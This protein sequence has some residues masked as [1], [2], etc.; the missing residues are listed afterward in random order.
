MDKGAEKLKNK[1]GK[2]IALHGSYFHHNF[3]DILLMDILTKWIR[4]YDKNYKVFLPFAPDDT[5]KSIGADGN[6]ISSIF[7]ADALVYGG[8]GYFGEPPKNQYKWG[9]RAIQR[10][11]PPGTLIRLRKKPYA[12]IG[13]GAGPVSNPLTKTLYTNICKNARVIS[14]RDE[15]SKEFL[16]ECG[17]DE[18]RVIKTSDIVVQL[19]RKDISEQW[20]QKVKKDLAVLSQPI[21]FGVHLGR[22]NFPEKIEIIRDEII[23]LAKNNSDI[24][25]VLI[26]DWKGKYPSVLDEIQNQIPNQSI[27]V[28]YVDHWYLCALLGSLDLVITTKL[29]V[30]ITAVALGKFVISVP[31]HTKTP[32]FYKQIG[33]Q[34]WCVPLQ[35]VD[36]ER[37]REL[38]FNG[39]EKVNEEFKVPQN[40]I[41]DAKKNKELLFSFLKNIN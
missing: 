30:G 14:V 9:L 34:D 10:H 22:S 4:E 5:T 33:A 36:K 26:C 17:L 18:K 3:G 38:L 25:L 28:P 19:T 8:G 6:G 39:L 37:I 20:F 29:H 16:V 11:V 27:I 31:A 40:V 41:V 12:I 35:L 2:I 13:V 24:G 32:R 21:K 7:K 23:D 1:F 15:E